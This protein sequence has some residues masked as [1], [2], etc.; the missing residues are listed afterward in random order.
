MKTASLAREQTQG[1]TFVEL[2]VA[3]V[4]GAAVLTA[5]VIGF[6]TLANIRPGPAG[7]T[8]DVTLP[9]GTLQNFYGM[10]NPVISVEPAPSLGEVARAESLREMLERDIGKAVAV[11][12]LARNGR[13]AVRPTNISIPVGMDGR[14]LES[15]EAFRAL[16][17]PGGSTFAP[18]VGAATNLLN[19]SLFILAP[20][21]SASGLRVQSIYEMDIVQATQPA[22]FYA[23]VRRYHGGLVSAFYHVFY[24]QSAAVFRPPV[25]FFER[26]ALSTG[27]INITNAFRGA[28]NRPFY[29]VWWPDPMQVRLPTNVP[30]AFATNARSVY[31]HLG[32]ATSYFLVLPAFPAL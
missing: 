2:L 16:V 24:P 6:G 13:S 14:S 18:Y 4:V 15:P 31:S 29:F 32:L 21:E 22:G 11:Y 26:S 12:C 10:T 9:S 1:F 23:S 7:A 20:S 17:D 27:S 8:L 5:A 30:A 25:A 3:I 19:T 28:A